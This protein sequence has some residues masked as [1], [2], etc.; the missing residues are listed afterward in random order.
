[1]N[2][3]KPEPTRK[4]IAG[5]EPK[6]GFHRCACGWECSEGND[7]QAEHAAHV[8]QLPA[9]VAPAPERF[10]TEHQQKVEDAAG[11]AI[12]W[13]MANAATVAA[14]PEHSI[15]RTL[16]QECHDLVM[17][18]DWSVPALIQAFVNFCRTRE[19]KHTASLAKA[20][21]DALQECCDVMDRNGV[22]G[23]SRTIVWI[24]SEIEAARA[25]RLTAPGR[26]GE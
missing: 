2:Q 5:H 15:D 16:E 24:D 9:Q 23:L 14:A 18:S 1:M 22:Q 19:E 12:D 8:A 25:L 11:M 6:T 3:S 4:I 10:L 13:G 21:E 26:S 20:R 17:Q 7:C